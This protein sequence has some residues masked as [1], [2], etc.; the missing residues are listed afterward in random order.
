MARQRSNQT[1]K[2]GFDAKKLWNTFKVPVVVLLIWGAVVGVMVTQAYTGELCPGHWHSTM[3]VYIDGEPLR[4]DHPAWTLEGR[5]GMPLRSHMH[6]GSPG[7]W[8]WEPQGSSICIPFNEGASHADLELQDDRLILN[9]RH[10]DVGQ[11][12]EYVDGADGKQLVVYMKPWGGD[13]EEVE[14]GWF[15]DRQ[16]MDGEKVIIAYGTPED[17]EMGLVTSMTT[18]LSDSLQPND[19]GRQFPVIPVVGIS[20]IAL[21][22]LA[23]WNNIRSKMA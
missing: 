3:D 19:T 15:A 1:E 2:P 6:Q 14:A 17:T 9:D 10:A 20:V 8:H 5:Q 23:I 12:G 7:I 4:F 18:P 16:M 22:F 21:V 11:D 13:W